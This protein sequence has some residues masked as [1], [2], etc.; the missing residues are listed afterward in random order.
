MRWLNRDPIGE[1][2]GK[3]LYGFCLNKATFAYDCLGRFAIYV[4]DSAI[5]HV[6]LR[7]E[8]GIAFDYGRYHGTYSGRGGISTG[9]NVLKTNSWESASR[10]R[11]YKV[12]EFNVCKILDDG[13]AAAA[14]SRFD[15]GT[16]QWPDEDR[17]VTLENLQANERYVWT[18]W[19]WNADNC[20]T[21][22]FRTI[23][24]GV[25]EAQKNGKLSP[26][27]QKQ[28]KVL[29]WL[30]FDSAWQLRPALVGPLLD[31]YSKSA[32]WISRVK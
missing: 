12:F 31:R 14:Q 32:D 28:A 17:F 10:F 30:A 21:F 19:S 5:G 22:T 2:G 8:G 9:P 20:M 6:G 15:G 16:T 26:K 23:V 27:A 3:S 4:D 25:K 13:I 18:D 11:E 1:A 29:L 24:A 7:V